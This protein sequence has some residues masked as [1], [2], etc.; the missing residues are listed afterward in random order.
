MSVDLDLA[1]LPGRLNFFFFFFC[2]G[3]GERKADE[4]RALLVNFQTETQ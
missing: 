4:F 2:P 3:Q 1:E